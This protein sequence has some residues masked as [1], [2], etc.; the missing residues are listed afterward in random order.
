[1][2]C[3]VVRRESLRYL[4]ALSLQHGL[5]LDQIDVTTAFLNGTLNEEVYMRQPEGFVAQGNEELV[6][7]LKKSIYYGLKQSRRC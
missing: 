5:I 2:F 1:M 7:K 4:I 6:C 3:P